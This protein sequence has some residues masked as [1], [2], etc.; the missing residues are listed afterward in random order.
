MK[1]IK[2]LLVGL[3]AHH[4]SSR[5]IHAGLYGTRTIKTRRNNKTQNTTTE[6]KPGGIMD[7]V[8]GLPGIA[9]RFYSF[10]AGVYPLGGGTKRPRL[11][12]Q[13]VHHGDKEPPPRQPPGVPRG[14]AS[15]DGEIEDDLEDARVGR[16]CVP[17]DRLVL[18]V[19]LEGV[20]P[21]PDSSFLEG[22]PEGAGGADGLCKRATFTS[23]N[24][25]P[26]CACSLCSEGRSLRDF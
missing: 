19:S 26:H 10:P 5:S 20:S 11:P 1:E 8:W 17:P 18:N 12:T 14:H 3:V 6:L 2:T 13:P 22:L 15:G 21:T 25:T 7:R 4:A 16:V 9:W 24:A 23:R